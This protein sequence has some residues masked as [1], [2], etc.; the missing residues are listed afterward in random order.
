MFSL[1]DFEGNHIL[2]GSFAAF[3][4]AGEAAEEFN[5]LSTGGLHTDVGAGFRFM[6]QPN[7]EM[8][9]DAAWGDDG[10][11][12]QSGFDQAF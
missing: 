6:L 3:A 10:M 7:A 5:K 1:H 2:T 9:I 8:R 4:E 11:L 12:I